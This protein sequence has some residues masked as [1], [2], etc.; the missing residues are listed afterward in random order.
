MCSA[1][2]L[3]YL[4]GHSHVLKQRLDFVV[5]TVMEAVK[6]EGVL[7]ELG[8]LGGNGRV[9]WLQPGLV[10]KAGQHLL[11]L[12]GRLG[13]LQQ[14]PLLHVVRGREALHH[15][16]GLVHVDG[17]ADPCQAV[18]PLLHP[19]LPRAQPSVS[20]PAPLQPPREP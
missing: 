5:P 16:E 1:E 4:I 2:S 13:L 10:V 19:A 12:H 9:D 6:A 18:G 11:L 3:A 8:V 14:H 20:A 7:T 15:R 17:V